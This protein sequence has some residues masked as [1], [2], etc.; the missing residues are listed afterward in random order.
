MGEAF[1]QSYGH[2]LG[3]GQELRARVLAVSLCAALADYADTDQRPLLL[4]ESLAG[5]RRA[6]T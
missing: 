3:A 5:L 6:Q 2:P 4:A 1:L